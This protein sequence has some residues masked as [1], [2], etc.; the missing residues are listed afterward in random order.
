MGKEQFEI[1]GTI[2]KKTAVD[3]V[4]KASRQFAMLY[5]HFSKVLVEEIGQAKAKELI[6][7]AVFDLAI[8][9]S[10]QL[11][12]QAEEAGIPTDGP[13]NFR[14]VT[15]IPFLGWVPEWGEDHCPYA[16][17]WRQYYEKY[18][19]FQDLAPFY[20]DVIDTTNIENFSGHLSHKITANVLTPGVTACKREYFE[21]KDVKEGKFTY[22]S[23]S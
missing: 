21:S 9:R 17:T 5:F 11:K 12:K 14:K 22:G 6:R 10:E 3:Q 1:T 7:K 4:R 15:D 2:D 20:C 13:E 23:R 19:W 16:E 18:P 8:D